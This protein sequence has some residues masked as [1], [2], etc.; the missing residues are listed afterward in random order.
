MKKSLIAVF[1]CFI[2]FS[3]TSKA[4]NYKFGHINLQEVIYLMPEMDSAKVV[5][6]KYGKD[7]QEIFVSMQNE[8]QTK[9]NTYQQ[10]QASWSQ[11]ILQAKVQEIQGIEQRIQQY[12]Q[13]A[14]QELSQKQNQVMAP[15]FQKANKAIQKVGKANGFTYIFDLSSG[16]VPYF[17]ETTSVDVSV[18]LKKELNIPLDKKLPIQ[19]TPQM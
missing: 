11:A 5:I 1:L 19:G 4:Q 13:S 18:L 6:E 12:Q 8:Y 9:V 14:E 16:T 10:M 15:I 7:L 3:F 17:D 2:A